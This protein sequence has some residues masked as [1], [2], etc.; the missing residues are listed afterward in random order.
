MGKFFNSKTRGLLGSPAPQAFLAHRRNRLTFSVATRPERRLSRPF[1]LSLGICTPSPFA[2]LLRPPVTSCVGLV[3]RTSGLFALV[4]WSG[5][6]LGPYSLFCADCRWWSSLLPTFSLSVSCMSFDT[7][8][9]VIICGIDSVVNFFMSFLR[10][11][12]L[13]NGM[14]ETLSG[15]FAPVGKRIL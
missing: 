15:E 5:L 14:W 10:L 9:L 8:S 3:G 1:F 13:W 12:I 2:S 6:G 4:L 7:S 11:L